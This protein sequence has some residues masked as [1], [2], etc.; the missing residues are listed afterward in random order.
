MQRGSRQTLPLLP[1]YEFW[2]TEIFDE[3]AYPKMH[4]VEQSYCG[5]GTNWWLPNQSC[6]EAM[7]RSAG[8]KIEEHP[9]GEVY[10]CRWQ[11]LDNPADG[12][13]AVYP[14]RASTTG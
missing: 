2:Q 1:D 3:A 14:A 9:E 12:F 7:L 4:F 8:F 13:H 11:Q 5:D 6:V 10:L